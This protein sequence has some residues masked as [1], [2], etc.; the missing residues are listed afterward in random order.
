MS[1]TDADT[2]VD[3]LA[4]RV[5]A[6]ERA[7]TDGHELAELP[8]GADLAATVAATDERVDDVEER[9]AEL[10]AAVQAVRGYVGNVRSVNR[11]VERRADAALA[12]VERLD[13]GS[14][15]LRTVLGEIE[16]DGS[17]FEFGGE[18]PPDGDAAPSSTPLDRAGAVVERVRA[19][20]RE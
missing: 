15:D 16:S 10:E 4:E 14:D 5:E 17:E 8:E 7:L 3:A 12:A 20:L 13:D 9:L 11:E 2:E 6:V 1:G 18:A 19:S